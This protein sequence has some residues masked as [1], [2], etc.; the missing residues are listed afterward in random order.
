VGIKVDRGEMAEVP[1]VADVVKIW[2][3]DKLR[4]VEGVEVDWSNDGAVAVDHIVGVPLNV[5]MV[6][7]HAALRALI[8]ARV[9][10]PTIATGSMPFALWKAATAR[11]VTRPK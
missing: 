8:F 4:D 9:F 2:L 10:G 1:E 11:S 5:L 7:S 3:T 6:V